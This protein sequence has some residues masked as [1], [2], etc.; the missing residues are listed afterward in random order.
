LDG[1]HGP[2]GRQRQHYRCYFSEGRFHRFTGML[3]REVV[4]GGVCEECENRIARHQGPAHPRHYMDPVRA[5]AAA[6]VAVGKGESYAAAARRARSS[7]GRTSTK[8]DGGGQLV[9]NWVEVFGPGILTEHTEHAWPE[10][11]LLDATDFKIPDRK[12]GRLKV[13]KGYP[14]D[15]T[16]L[17]A[18]P[19]ILVLASTTRG[20]SAS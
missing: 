12:T 13:A 4:T 15:R 7:H 1:V 10:T 16:A 17:G 5:Q 2:L 19:T 9:A 14:S 11:L 8:A 18:W 20:P 3:T 6:L